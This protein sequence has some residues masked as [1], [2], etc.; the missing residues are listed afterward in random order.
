MVV[1]SWK[2]A[3]PC[4]YTHARTHPRGLKTREC[5]VQAHCI[6]VLT[7]TAPTVRAGAGSRITLALLGLGFLERGNQ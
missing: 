5:Q 3:H 4:L 7:G 6:P 2:D 1:L